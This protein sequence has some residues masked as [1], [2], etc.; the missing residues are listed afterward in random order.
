MRVAL[1]NDTHF[2]VRSDNSLFYDYFNLF[3]NKCFFPTIEHYNVQKII[4]LGD[5]LDRRKYVNFNTLNWV[6]E[7]FLD[8]TKNYEIDLII[9]NHDTYYK[10]SNNLNSP[11]LITSSYPN[12]KVY[13]SP[14]EVNNI[15]YLPWITSENRDMTMQM[16]HD[17]TCTVAMGHLEINGYVM[18]KGVH[19]SSGLNP[20]I[21]EKFKSVYTGHFHTK[22]ESAN[23][24][25]LGSPWDLIFT[26][27]EDVK[28]FHLYDTETD[29]L[30]FFE[31]PY[32]MY[33]KFYYDDVSKTK[34]MVLLPP[35]KL[36]KLNKSFVKVYVKSKS[37]QKLFD[38]Y[39]QQINEAQPASL[40]LFED[41][42]TIESDQVDNINI[43][44]DT[45][46]MIRSSIDDY[47]ELINTEE[48]KKRIEDLLTKIYIESIKE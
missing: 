3:L 8:K 24:Y 29:E 31:N 19:C 44:E 37:K 42:S 20:S 47:S 46:S 32:K 18:Y 4:H 48:S 35:S 16:I 43:S 30:E 5:F 25:Y 9:G 21:F 22:N 23:I 28:G 17:S 26:D 34:D 40:I 41:Y 1:L 13:S 2:G 39:V 33:W 38:K 15:L 14:T 36:K 27:S 45:L 7:N 6:K 12:I 10:N 11:D